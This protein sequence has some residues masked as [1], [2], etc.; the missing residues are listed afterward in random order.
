MSMFSRADWR[1]Y[2][3]AKRALEAH[4]EHKCERK[5]FWEDPE[6]LRLNEAVGVAAR[7]VG[8]EW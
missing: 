6:Y 8:L 2:F 3:A 4:G 5:E 1:A 7:K